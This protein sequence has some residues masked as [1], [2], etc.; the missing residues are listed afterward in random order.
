MSMC[1][2]YTIMSMRDVGVMTPQPH[3]HHDRLHR[4]WRA[5]RRISTRKRTNTAPRQCCTLPMALAAVAAVAAPSP[6]LRRRHGRRAS[7]LTLV[8]EVAEI[9]VA[10][11][12]QARVGLEVLPTAVRSLHP[13]GTPP[14]RLWRSSQAQSRL[15]HAEAA[16]WR[17]VA[18]A[19]A[20]KRPCRG[21]RGCRRGR[22]PRRT[23][24]AQQHLAAVRA[25]AYWR[26][27]L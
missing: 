9:S 8:E 6:L 27:R 16:G 14:R 21:C 17:P 3:V 7:G 23:A 24:R 11:V 20:R 10:E 13:H 26:C 18:S 25:A 15:P 2:L 5:V 22:P 1:P 4:R 19:A 12:E